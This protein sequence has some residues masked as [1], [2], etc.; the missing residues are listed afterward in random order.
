MDTR[1]FF[2]GDS[3]VNGTGDP[4]GLGWV[5]RVCANVQAAGPQLTFYNLGVRADTTT[6]IVQRWQQEVQS[7]LAPNSQVGFVFSF[8]AND[9]NILEGHQRVEQSESLD[10]AKAILTKAQAMGPVLIVGSPPIADDPSANKRL[11]ALWSSIELL[12]QDR[13]IP[14][15]PTLETLVNTPDWMEEAIA[16]DGAHPQASGYQA[17]ANLLLTSPTWQS[18]ISSLLA[19]S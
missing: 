2:I 7:R 6:L 5:G 12:C 17:L 4:E 9:V 3:F 1:L 8:G 13:N 18:W 15:I 19:P 16:N 11:E 10:N 14:C